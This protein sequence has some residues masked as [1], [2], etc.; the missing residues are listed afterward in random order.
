MSEGKNIKKYSAADIER[1]H[2]GQL[3]P[4]ERHDLEKAALD[5]PFL[6]DALEG[7][8]NAGNNISADISE[9]KTRLAERLEKDH[10]A[11]VVPIRKR[12]T[13]L[14]V[15]VILVMLV[16]TGILVYQMMFQKHNS[17]EIAQVPVNTV[18]RSKTDSNVNTITPGIASNAGTQELSMTVHDTTPPV[19]TRREIAKNVNRKTETE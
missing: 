1:Y 14:R 12:Y 6:A 15:A 9:L 18:V 10:S 19:S 4:K 2:K 5:D 16:G 13:F 11:P 3:S 7:Y 17:K 8:A